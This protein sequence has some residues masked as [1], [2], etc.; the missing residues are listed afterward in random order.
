MSDISKIK[1]NDTTY[2]VKD[3]LALRDAPLDGG[4]YVRKNGEWQISSSGS[5]GGGSMAAMYYYQQTVNTASN[6]E[7][8]RITDSR[9]NTD[10]IVL[11]CTFANPACISTDVTWTSYF[12]YIAFTGTCTA[13]TTANVTLGYKS[14]DTII[15]PIGLDL[16]YEGNPANNTTTNLFTGK[17]F[18]DYKLLT[19]LVGDTGINRFTYTL[20]I[21]AEFFDTSNNNWI[22]TNASSIWAFNFR[23]VSD[24]SFQARDKGS[25]VSYI[26]LYGDSKYSKIATEKTKITHLSKYSGASEP[27]TF[28]GSDMPDGVYLLYIGQYGYNANA[29]L[30]TVAFWE[31]TCGLCELVPRAHYNIT[32]NG[33][34]FT[35]APVSSSVNYFESHLFLLYNQ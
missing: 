30:Y 7:I 35:V 3:S 32:T 27:Q 2:N 17:K 6:A 29:A 19:I 26:R 28:D 4:E 11:E 13:A 20:P 22:E 34:S 18:S 15:T 12:G 16:I 10:T 5:G 14:E 8:F 23:Y 9:I 21:G 1:I 24:T 33:R 31:N 25:N